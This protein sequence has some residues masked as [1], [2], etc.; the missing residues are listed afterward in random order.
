MTVS[1]AAA[2]DMIRARC[3]P[4]TGAEAV[5]LDAADARILAEAIIAPIDV[6]ESAN[7][8]VDGYGF[9][10]ADQA[11]DRE[12]GLRVVGI[13]AAGRMLDRTIGQG[14]AVRLF[15]GAVP[16]PGVD[17]IA[18]QEEATRRGDRVILNGEIQLG[19]NIR[20]AGE[21]IPGG[22]LVFEAGRQLGPFELGMLA[23]LGLAAIPARRLLRVAVLS[24]G[25][26]L[27]NPGSTRVAGAVFD[28]NRPML[29]AMLRRMGMEASDIGIVADDPAA[30]AAALSRA[31]VD[32]DAI[33]SSAGMSVGDED[34]LRHAAETL[35]ALDFPSVAIKP[36]KPFAFGHIAGTPFFGLPGN[37]VAMMVTFLMLARPGLLRLAGATPKEPRRF[38]VALDFSI[39]RRAGRRE[40]LR[41]GLRDGPEGP[42]AAR[43]E[44]GGAGILSSM[45]ESDG[46]IELAEDVAEAAPGTRLP[47][48][49]FREFG[50]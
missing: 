36:G 28:A 30:I 15:T 9:R 44:R 33:V 2:L 21:D 19:A 5:R 34:H 24:A 3:A 48:I 7:S 37:P 6:P 35:G 47:F 46:L 4:T 1:F 49:P 50:V 38:P 26:E 29:M 14:E 27:V 39:R 11:V 42:L 18:M 41:C 16:P 25:D 17:A 20:A 8:A 31:A 45:G 23:S 12:G 10:H 13:A 22:A 40:F 43:Y 32:H